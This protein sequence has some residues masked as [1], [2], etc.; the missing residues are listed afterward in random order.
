[1]FQVNQLRATK[2]SGTGHY[3]N[4][5][6]KFEHI[7]SIENVYK[8]VNNPFLEMIDIKC[9]FHQIMKSLAECKEIDLT[10]GKWKANH[11]IHKAT[12]YS[13]EVSGVVQSGRG[14]KKLH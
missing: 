3:L 12:L 1:M 7:K 13:I 14:I 11:S 9:E 2:G 6:S 5:D 10:V 4:K 8:L